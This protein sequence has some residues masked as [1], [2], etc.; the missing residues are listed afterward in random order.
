[1]KS[2]LANAFSSLSAVRKALEWCGENPFTFW[3]WWVLITFVLAAASVVL[4][5]AGVT[6]N[7]QLKSGFTIQHISKE[8]GYLAA[9]NWS[10]Y[11][12]AVLPLLMLSSVAVWSTIPRTLNA[13]A[14]SGM[15]RTPD[16]QRVE[17]ASLHEHWD[18]SR[19][20]MTSM[21]VVIVVCVFAFVMRDWW[22]TVGHPI[23]N[24]HVMDGVGLNDSELEYDWSIACIYKGSHVG[25]GP[26][27]AFG[28][29]AYIIIPGVGTALAFAT[30]ICALF[31]VAFICGFAG[32]T[33]RWRLIAAPNEGDHKG[34]FS[35]F[36]EF[37]TALLSLCILIVVGCILMIMQN[38][39]LREPNYNSIVSMMFGDVGTI[40]N[41]PKAEVGEVI[42]IGILD[43]LF[44]PTEIFL[45]NPQS[46]L[47]VLITAL[48][49]LSI[50]GMS[51]GLLRATARS[52]QKNS[53]EHVNSL[54]GE[55]HLSRRTAVER[56]REMDFWPV[57]WMKQNQLILLMICLSLCIVSYRMLLLPLAWIGFSGIHFA[58]EVVRKMMFEDGSKDE[59]R[60][61]KHR[62]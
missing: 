56:L 52:A 8:V 5:N 53:L 12:I 11:G 40:V 59:G 25:C 34:G 60:R 10:I 6:F 19:S 62:D 20:T 18:R 21:F 13:L 37:F 28:L 39:Y 38:T 43:W 61:R 27:F 58:Y 55:F 29:I 45:Q 24:P 3:V 26:L 33:G 49:A 44:K 50:L 7:G 51:W 23:L 4:G 16:F 35:H 9:V 57:G 2:R 1:V 54:A 42:H 14:D 47:G 32:N 41:S 31:F 36:A 22:T 30:A 46:G 15:I 48:V 17:R